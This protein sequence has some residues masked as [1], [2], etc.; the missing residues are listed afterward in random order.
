MKVFNWQTIKKYSNY[1]GD[2]YT[3]IKQPVNEETVKS[4]INAFFTINNLIK[5]ANKRYERAIANK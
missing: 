3:H 5:E 1:V 4:V 2:S